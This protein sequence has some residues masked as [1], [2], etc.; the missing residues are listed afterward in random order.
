M[1]ISQNMFYG[2]IAIIVL[3]G[4]IVAIIQWRRVRKLNKD[5]EFL[6]K[7][8]E[9][10]KVEMF[11]NGQEP[12]ETTSI[13]LPKAQEKNLAQIMK[14]ISNLMYKKGC[15]PNQIDIRFK[16]LESSTRATKFQKLLREIE[17]K[18]LE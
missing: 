15:L 10:K 1:E 17:M 2:I 6:N 13:V 5:V 16:R 14:I 4:V 8:A 18:K 3:A 9:Q 11:R 7:L 12:Q